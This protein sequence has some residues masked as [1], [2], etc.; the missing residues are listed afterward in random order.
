MET[1]TK[2]EKWIKTKFNPLL[3]SSTP[4]G[5]HTRKLCKSSLPPADVTE[6]R[7]QEGKFLC[8]NGQNKLLIYFMKT[9]SSHFKSSPPDEAGQQIF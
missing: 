6:Y 2:E 8:S 4:L 1:M 7:L 3:F 5:E 9:A